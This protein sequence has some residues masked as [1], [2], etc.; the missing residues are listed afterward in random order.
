MF[1]PPTAPTVAATRAMLT[2][3]TSPYVSGGILELFGQVG[4][5]LAGY[6]LGRAVEALGWPGVFSAAVGVTL[7]L[8]LLHAAA[9][10]L[11]P[12]R[13]TIV[14]PSP[15]PKRGS[16]TQVPPSTPQAAAPGMRLRSGRCVST[17]VS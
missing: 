8:V 12:A 1:Y 9:L 3:T 2:G 10:Q 15:G 5:S 14:S 4:A 11:F 17:P 13:S 7:L 6:P 16:G